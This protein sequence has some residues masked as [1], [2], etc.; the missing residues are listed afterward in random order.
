MIITLVANWKLQCNYC[1][2]GARVRIGVGLLYFGERPHFR[3]PFIVHVLS[4][5][6]STRSNRKWEVCVF[7]FRPRWEMF[8]MGSKKLNRASRSVQIGVSRVPLDTCLL[9]LRTF[10]YYLRCSYVQDVGIP[11]RF[12]VEVNI[13]YKSQFTC[14][15]KSILCKFLPLFF[16]Y[17]KSV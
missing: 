2:M 17:P 9:F 5:W 13:T 14:K 11:S 15:K 12:R 1:N 7:E 10:C 6:G 3:A 8:K 4:A 16:L